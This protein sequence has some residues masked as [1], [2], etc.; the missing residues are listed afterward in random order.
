[1]SS[2]RIILLEKLA[3]GL[4]PKGFTRE[5]AAMAPWLEDWRKRYRGSAAAMLSPAT[6]EEVAQIV[7]LCASER[8]ALVPQGGNTSMVAGATPD[9]EGEC[10]LLSLRRLNRIR[11]VSAAGNSAVCEAGVILSELHAAAAEAGRRFPL[12]LGAKGSATIGGLI[13]TNAGGRRCCVSA[14][15]AASSRDW[16][17]CFRTGPST[18][19]SPRSRRTIAATT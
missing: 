1:M 9:R 5:P 8:V 10:L 19:G 2:S 18:Q 14:R 3:A 6:T 4:G 16:K 13:S 11:S 17:R 7:R 12:T 15:C